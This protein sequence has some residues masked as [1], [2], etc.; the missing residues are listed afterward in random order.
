L[1]W[2]RGEEAA[3]LLAQVHV[4]PVVAAKTGGQK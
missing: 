2:L 3:V 4:W 1:A